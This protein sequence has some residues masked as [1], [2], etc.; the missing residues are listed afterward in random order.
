MQIPQ[1]LDLHAGNFV[2][3]DLDLSQASWKRLGSMT[4]DNN[5]RSKFQAREL[6][7]V[8]VDVCTQ[9]LK[10]ILCQPHANEL[11]KYHQVQ[12]SSL[13]GAQQLTVIKTSAQNDREALAKRSRN[14]YIHIT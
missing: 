6:K 13:H 1:R 10:V 11:N 4:F 7:S 2:S 5:E 14:K 3:E 8:Q 9:L 12:A